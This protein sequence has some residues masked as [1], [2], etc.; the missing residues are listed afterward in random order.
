MLKIL[1]VVPEFYLEPNSSVKDFFSPLFS[2]IGTEFDTAVH[3]LTCVSGVI[4]DN[5]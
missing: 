5:A 2:E 3:K 4:G 1:G